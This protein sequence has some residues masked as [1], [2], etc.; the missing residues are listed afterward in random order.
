[1]PRKNK[2]KPPKHHV[3]A[4]SIYDNGFKAK[5]HGCAFAG[6]GFIC[7]T[8]DGKCLKGGAG[9]EVDTTGGNAAKGAGRSATPN[10][11]PMRPR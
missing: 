4:P 7:L 6:L 1:M 3:H 8:S 2:R 5:C 10:C 9:T 11:S